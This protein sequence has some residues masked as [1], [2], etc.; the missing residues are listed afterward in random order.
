MHANHCPIREE[1]TQ[2]RLQEDEEPE[3]ELGAVPKRDCAVPHRRARA[4]TPYGPGRVRPG[5]EKEAPVAR[6]WE[7]AGS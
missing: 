4:I 5:R 1:G 6:W 7:L 2:R 3:V